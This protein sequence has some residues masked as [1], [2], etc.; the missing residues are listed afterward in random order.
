MAVEDGTTVFII[1]HDPSVAEYAD[2]VLE[3][4]E[5]KLSHV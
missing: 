4:R 3:L 1:S 2:Q 5:G